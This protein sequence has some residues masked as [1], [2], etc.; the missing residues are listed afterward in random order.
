MSHNFKK[1]IRVA[2]IRVEDVEYERSTHYTTDYRRKVLCV[3]FDDGSWWVPKDG[4][5]EELKA[6]KR[7]VK[8]HNYQFPDPDKSTQ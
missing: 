6:K 8:N 4:E 1:M 2:E 7:E 3:H 5:L